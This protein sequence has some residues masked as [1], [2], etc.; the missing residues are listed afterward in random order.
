MRKLFLILVSGMLVAFQVMSCGNNDNPDVIA[1]SPEGPTIVK[2]DATLQFTANVPV[3]WSVAGGD[4]NGTIGADGLYTPPDTLPVSYDSISILAEDEEGNSAEAF[5]DLRA[6]DTLVFTAPVPVNSE[7]I[8]TLS[9][10]ASILLGPVNDYF[11]AASQAV[12]ILSVWGSVDGSST[13][14]TFF[15]HNPAF[16]GFVP[17]IPVTVAGERTFPVALELDA[18]DNPVLMAATEPTP[19]P[20]STRISILT[21]PDGGT[22]F[23]NPVPVSTLNPT[24]EQEGGSFRRDNQGDLHLVLRETDTSVLNGPTNIFYARS[25]DGG[26][27]WSDLLPLSTLVDDTVDVI[28]PFVGVSGDGQN[29]VACWSQ[30]DNIFY[31]FSSDGG[32]NFSAAQALTT[33]DENLICRI[34]RGPEDQFYLTYTAANA[35]NEAKVVLRTSTDG[36]ATFGSPVFVNGTTPEQTEAV[37][38]LAV[39]D[40]GRID[41]VWLSDPTA[42]D[43][44]DIV[45]ARSLD[46]GVTFSPKVTLVDSTVANTLALPNGLRHD[47]AGR[48]YLQYFD[49]FGSMSTE[50]NLSLLYGE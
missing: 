18:Q 4:T 49:A 38:W 12:D 25:N 16:A 43:M 41:V 46:G 9:V 17:Q 6:A 30:D 40:L 32:D 31:S 24:F 1:I 20:S 42:S 50:I 3:T 22:T 27:I 35:S 13:P 34:A 28:F 45:Y 29:V 26:V 37:T 2:R 48:L 33:T 44:G 19:T 21:S 7:P 11:A 39:D 47:R 14:L 36:G 5:V 8:E 23:D 15:S 10:F